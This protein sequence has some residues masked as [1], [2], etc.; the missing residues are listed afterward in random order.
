MDSK[1][2][3]A[4]I[5]KLK[6]QDAFRGINDDISLSVEHAHQL[7]FDM[8]IVLRPKYTLILDC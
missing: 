5:E 2:T 6:S 1:W 4:D 8:M 7:R 3:N